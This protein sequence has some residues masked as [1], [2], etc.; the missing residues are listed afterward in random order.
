MGAFQELPLAQIVPLPA[1]AKI[2]DRACRVALSGFGQAGADY[3]AVGGVISDVS[4]RQPKGM[5]DE[6]CERGPNEVGD[7]AHLGQR[8]GTQA[9]L[10]EDAL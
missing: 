8:D 7:L 5:L 6:A 3:R 2:D 9:A 1:E 4:E 10:V